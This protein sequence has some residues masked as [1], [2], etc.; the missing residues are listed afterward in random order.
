MIE[1]TATKD[2]LD[3]KVTCWEKDSLIVNTECRTIEK[4]HGILDDVFELKGI[5]RQE[6]LYGNHEKEEA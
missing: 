4:V 6:I 5:A 2:D 1:F 3:F